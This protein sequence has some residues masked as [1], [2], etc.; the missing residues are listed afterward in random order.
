VVVEDAAS[1]KPIAA[2]QQEDNIRF[3]TKRATE[4]MGTRTRVTIRGI[5]SKPNLNC[6]TGLSAEVRRRRVVQFHAKEKEFLR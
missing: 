4:A 1:G 2:Q 6:L 3:K 5:G